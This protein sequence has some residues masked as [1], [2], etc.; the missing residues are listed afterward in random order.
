MEND[1]LLFSRLRSLRSRKRIVKKDVEKQIRKK[2]KR[3]KELWKIKR[4]IPWIAL[5]EPYQRGFVRFFAVTEEVM[6]T[7]D[8]DFFEGILKKINTFMYSEIRHFLKKKRKFGRRIYVEREQKLKSISSY[9]WN[10]PKIQFAARERQY[11][12]KRREY[13]P[14]RKMYYDYYDFIEPWRFTLRIKPNMI[15]H[16]KPVNAELEKEYAEVEFYVKQYKV[17]GIIQKKI[18]GKSNSWK[19][20]YESDLNESRK[21][22][23]Y[24][25]MSAT[26]FADY[27]MDE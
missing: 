18:Y 2:Y 25:K 14:F 8:A 20:K 7:K 23:H 1:N 11:F 22:F 6:R 17:Q 9:E 10:N 15:T 3:S 16:Y 13:C 21:Y 26:E 12:L 5:E 27:F 4:D 24:K 19:I